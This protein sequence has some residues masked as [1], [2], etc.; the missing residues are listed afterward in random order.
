MRAPAAG[1]SG[2]HDPC[3]RCLE[4]VASAATI[5]AHA[6]KAT[7]LR[8]MGPFRPAFRPSHAARE[9]SLVNRTP[10][11]NPRPKPPGIGQ[12]LRVSAPTSPNTPR[13]NELQ[14]PHG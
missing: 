2:G 10:K 3:R 9:I 11:N 12:S 6:L 1:S 5:A 14:E 4:G 7:H 8:R 13:A